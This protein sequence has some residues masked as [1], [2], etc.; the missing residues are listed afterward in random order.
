MLRFLLNF[1]AP[2]P[3]GCGCGKW[4]R[5]EEGLSRC[6]WKHALDTNE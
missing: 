2:K 1:F 5:N 6:V 3:Y 4:Y